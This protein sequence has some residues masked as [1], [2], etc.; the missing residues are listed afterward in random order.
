DGGRTLRELIGFIVAA[1]VEAFRKRNEAR[2]LDRV[3]SAAEI[4]EGEAR[5]RISPEGR[6]TP[7]AVDT[8]EA[9]A[10]A[11]QAFEDGLY[12]VVIDGQEHRDLEAQVFLRPDSRIT[13]IRLVF[14]AGA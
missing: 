2:R 13:F 14:L 8:E 7:G 11:I 1:E 4:E 5:G 9:V 12:L 6:G 10:A 3:L